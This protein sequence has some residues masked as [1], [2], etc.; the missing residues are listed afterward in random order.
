MIIPNEEGHG[1]L[2]VHNCVKWLK[3]GDFRDPCEFKD[4]SIL[5][6]DFPLKIDRKIGSKKITF[7]FWSNP[8]H[9][10]KAAWKRV[11]GVICSGVGHEF[12][13]W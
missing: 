1:R 5:D 9:F 2:N 10:D 6:V 11:V 8:Q 3:H 4:C 12:R 7:E 13:D